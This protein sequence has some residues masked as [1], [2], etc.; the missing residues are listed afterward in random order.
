[1]PGGVGGAVREYLAPLSR[2]RSRTRSTQRPGDN[3]G[4]E[5]G[6]TALVGRDGVE[7]PALGWLRS[8]PSSFERDLGGRGFTHATV[9]QAF[10]HHLR[11][12]SGANTAKGWKAGNGHVSP[13]VGLG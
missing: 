9:K 4:G 1:M 5:L 6:V 12:I 10:A 11:Q 3:V 13:Q 7:G 8:R 2:L